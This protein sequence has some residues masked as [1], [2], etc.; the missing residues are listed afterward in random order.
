[1]TGWLTLKAMLRGEAKVKGNGWDQTALQSILS[2][3]F[4]PRRADK[5]LTCC[6]LEGIT[7][8][9]VYLREDHFA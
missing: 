2:L 3:A 6:G 9:L 5:S 1:M 8:R 4:V 7:E